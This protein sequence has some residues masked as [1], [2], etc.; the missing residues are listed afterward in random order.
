MTFD[1]PKTFTAEEYFAIEEADP[2]KNEYINGE[3]RAMP[4]V[5]ADHVLI[6][7]NIVAGL[8][9]Q[10]KD[11]PGNVLM[12]RMRLKVKADFYTYADTIVVRD[13]IVCDENDNLLNP[14]VIV[15][16]LSKE[17]EAYDRG[18]K[19]LRYRKLESFVEYVL[20]AQDKP[21]VEHYFRQSENAWLISE[22]TDL[23]DSIHLSSVGCHLKLSDIYHKIEFKEEWEEEAD[24]PQRNW[25]ITRK[26]YA[27]NADEALSRL[28][29]FPA[30]AE[31]MDGKLF[32]S[33]E[34]RLI[35][36]GCLLENVGIDKALRFCELQLWKDAIAD[37]EK[38]EID[39]RSNEE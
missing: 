14:T 10:L 24:M 9:G 29:E 5:N 28:R 37:L 15:E 32:W 6:M 11:K 19:F 36:L 8:H 27:W 26:G 30:K 34:D 16:I 4:H 18:E 22:T 7:G 13:E 21:R 12:S 1:P 38:H 33:E 17:S 2:W 31:M 23:H 20:V 39:K 3:I 35:A 25:N